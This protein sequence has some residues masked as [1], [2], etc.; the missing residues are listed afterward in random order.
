MTAAHDRPSSP[1]SNISSCPSPFLPTLSSSFS[2]HASL[3]AKDLPSP[4]TSDAGAE[5]VGRKKETVDEAAQEE[6]D[7]ATSALRTLC[8]A[9]E[10]GRLVSIPISSDHVPAFVRSLPPLLLDFYDRQR[11]DIHPSRLDIY[12]P[13]A[14]HEVV[15]ETFYRLLDRKVS[16]VL[17]QLEGSGPGKWQLMSVGTAHV[18]VTVYP[19]TDDS[20]EG[21]DTEED[22]DSSRGGR[23]GI[24]MR[25]CPDKK[26]MIAPADYRIEGDSVPCPFVFE[27]ARTQSFDDLND[28]LAKYSRFSN[29]GS[30]RWAI[31]TF[32]PPS[33][34]QAGL[35]VYGPRADHYD[36]L[37][38]NPLE[39][40]I[41]DM[42]SLEDPDQIAFSM[43]LIDITIESERENLIRATDGM[44]LGPFIQFTYSDLLACTKVAQTPLQKPAQPKTRKR[45]FARGYPPSKKQRLAREKRKAE[46]KSPL[47]SESEEDVKRRKRNGDRSFVGRSVDTPVMEARVLRPRVKRSVS[48]D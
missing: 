31:G 19:D 45:K 12:M 14:A 10:P 9:P 3:A 38:E 16:A 6:I 25:F 17:G 15:V 27:N 24:L 44:G 41:R 39:I 43:Y 35:I 26:M 29:D 8:S 47:E 30:V 37:V 18:D 7:A 40:E 4:P 23:E 34:T 5:E 36:E 32:A 1:A 13:S 46:E 20:A 28:K 21:T 22:E 33:G 11:I 2:S 48:R 42:N